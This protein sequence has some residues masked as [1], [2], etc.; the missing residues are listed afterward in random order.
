MTEERNTRG[1]G[2]QSAGAADEARVEALGR[3]LG[4]HH[5][6]VARRARPPLAA[7]EGA[8]EERGDE[9]EA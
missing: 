6:L 4:E 2:S 3:V 8:G 1:P 7:R 9:N 5:H